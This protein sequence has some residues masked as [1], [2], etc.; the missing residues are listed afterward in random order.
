MKKFL[1]PEVEVVSF[2]VADIVTTSD[3]GMS[4]IGDCL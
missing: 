3:D 4:F 2:A 1:E